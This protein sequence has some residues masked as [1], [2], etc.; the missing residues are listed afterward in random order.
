MNGHEHSIFLVDDDEDDCL[1]IR[2]AFLEIH[3]GTKLVLFATGQDLIDHLTT[4]SED[5]L[6][7]LILLDL[8]MPMMNG[9][10]VLQT[11]RA[12]ELLQC[13]P[14]LILSGGSYKNA[15][16]EC[17]R[18]GANAFMSKPSSFAELIGIL[19]ETHAYWLK[20]VRIPSTVGTAPD[21]R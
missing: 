5:E 4:L 14:V 7:S 21:L 17:Y 19:A 2:D 13:I 12:N 8:N 15:I 10:E 18:L 3:T 16:K 9:Y 11:L 1:L 20:T 6:P